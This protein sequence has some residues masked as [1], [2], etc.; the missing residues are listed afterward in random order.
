MSKLE[1]IVDDL[2]ALTVL[3]SIASFVV[4]PGSQWF[5][6][7]LGVRALIFSLAVHYLKPSSERLP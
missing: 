6:A 4:T 1:K 2:S 5:H 3:A 7:M